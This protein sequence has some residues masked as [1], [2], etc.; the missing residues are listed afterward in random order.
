MLRFVL[1]VVARDE[2]GAKNV[3]M[4]FQR[5]S[6]MIFLNL[7]PERVSGASS[8]K[9]LGLLVH[10]HHDAQDFGNVHGMRL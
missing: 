10:A 7:A 8:L 3:E 4:C 2:L 9:N 6:P 1:G 5:F